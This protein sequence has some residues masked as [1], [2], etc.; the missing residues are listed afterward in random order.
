MIEIRDR[1][2]HRVCNLLHSPEVCS[3]AY[4]RPADPSSRGRSRI[5]TLCDFV[6]AV[7]D[8]RASRAARARRANAGSTRGVVP[9]PSAAANTSSASRCTRPAVSSIPSAIRTRRTMGIAHP[10]GSRVQGSAEPFLL[11]ATRR[12][13]ES[14]RKALVILPIAPPPLAVCSSGSTVAPLHCGVGSN[15]LKAPCT[16]VAALPACSPC[17]AVSDS[18]FAPPVRTCPGHQSVVGRAVRA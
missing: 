15:G 8:L 1:C 13:N 17:S 12:R 10:A 4:R 16:N 5:A 6:S 9:P 11:L 2:G 18:A 3:E 7:R 14:W